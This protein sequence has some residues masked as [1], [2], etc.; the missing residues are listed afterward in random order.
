MSG[1]SKRPPY[2]LQENNQSET[3]LIISNQ[4]VEHLIQLTT[5]TNALVKQIMSQL[6]PS[7]RKKIR[8]ES[9]INANSRVTTS[10]QHNNTL[11]ST[12]IREILVNDNASSEPVELEKPETLPFKKKSKKVLHVVDC[13]NTVL[14]VV[15]TVGFWTLEY[16]VSGSKSVS[17][18][19][20]SPST[21]FREYVEKASPMHEPTNITD[22]MIQIMSRLLHHYTTSSSVFV[23]PFVVAIEQYMTREDICLLFQKYTLR[24]SDMKKLGSKTYCVAVVLMNSDFGVVLYHIGHTM[25]DK[26]YPTLTLICSDSKSAKNYCVAGVADYFAIMLGFGDKMFRTTYTVHSFDDP[27]GNIGAFIPWSFKHFQSSNT[28]FVSGSHMMTIKLVLSFISS[29]YTGNKHINMLNNDFVNWRKPCYCKDPGLALRVH[30]SK[31]C[32]DMMVDAIENKLY[33]PIRDDVGH[34]CGHLDPTN[35]CRTVTIMVEHFMAKIKG[36]FWKFFLLSHDHCCSTTFVNLANQQE[37]VHIQ[38]SERTRAE[39]LAPKMNKN[40]I[41]KC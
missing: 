20:P 22:C 11:A 29:V 40:P 37:K 28:P 8:F 15:D 27:C 38:P 4:Q 1:S 19:V 12:D 39:G 3:S 26:T 35:T 41:C 2:F 14:K 18:F 24:L 17:L 9:N 16:N 30:T 31:I 36:I 25:K 33:K 7:A 5:E 10:I 23:V 34:W 6:A 13:D 21:W 32:Y